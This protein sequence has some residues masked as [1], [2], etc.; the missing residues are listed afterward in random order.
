[1]RSNKKNNVKTNMRSNNTNNVKTNKRS[2]TL[3]FTLFLISYV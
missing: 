2:P 1:M 3:V